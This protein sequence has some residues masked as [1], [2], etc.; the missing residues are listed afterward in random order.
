M[1]QRRSVLTEA[2]REGLFTQSWRP[3]ASL[4]WYEDWITFLKTHTNV[5]I[6]QAVSEVGDSMLH[7]C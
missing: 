6:S 4:T 2:P 5:F 3:D 1:Q 7:D